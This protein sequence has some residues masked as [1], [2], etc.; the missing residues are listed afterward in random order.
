[1]TTE[2]RRAPR[3]KITQ[4]HKSGSW[5]KVEYHHHLECGHIEV[6]KRSAPTGEIACAWCLR[7]EVRDKEIK[8][9]VGAKPVAL[10]PID[11]E[12]ADDE[13]T[14]ERTRATI[15]AR[16]GVPVD[17]VDITSGDFNGRLVVRSATIYL[18][19]TD[20]DKL[21]RHK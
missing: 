1:M 15:A 9:L 12:F 17:A 16:F 4:I 6:R 10:L 5:G 19:A 13:L 21:T 11:S 14:I 18:S 7:A 2:H 20:V 8:A 3:K